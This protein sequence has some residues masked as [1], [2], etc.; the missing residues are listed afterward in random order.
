M[1]V[2]ENIRKARKDLRMSQE[3]LAEA[4]GSNRVT[5]SQYETGGYLPSLT[6][7]EKLAAALRTTP[8]ALSGDTEAFANNETKA[9]IT[10][11]ARV[12]GHGADQMPAEDRKRLLDMVKL[13]FP[14]YADYFEKGTETDE[15]EH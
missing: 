10:V 4:I 9:P 14:Q 2:G 3:Q 7:L 15:R 8:A 13:V 12:L 1:N 11:E 6:A 5:I